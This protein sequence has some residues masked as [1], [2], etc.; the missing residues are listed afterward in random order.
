[1]AIEITFWTVLG[2]IA[3]WIVMFIIGLFILRYVN[4]VAEKEGLLKK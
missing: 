4:K 1:M 3:F 2:V